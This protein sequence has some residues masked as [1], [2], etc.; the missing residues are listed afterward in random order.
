MSPTRTI[1]CPSRATKTLGEKV[2]PLT[3]IGIRYYRETYVPYWDPEQGFRLDCNAA[4]GLPLFGED[5]VS[6]MAWGQASWVTAPP[7][8]MGWFSDVKF[9][10]R[11]FAG[12]GFPRNGR[13]FTLG[14]SQLF[15]GFDYAECQGSCMWVGSA[16]VRLP[17]CPHADV[18]LFDRIVRIENIYVVPFYDVGDMYVNHETV[19]GVAHALGL[20]LRFDL[21]FFRFLERATLRLDAAQ[22]INSNTGVQFWFGL[23][24]AF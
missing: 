11:A 15:R 16:E 6:G 14:G 18:D 17:V 13:L 9:G 19:G 1:G 12:I 2:D 23:Q 3:T 8:G 24:Q 4:L 21:S 7:E 20:G 10:L 22:A 5:D